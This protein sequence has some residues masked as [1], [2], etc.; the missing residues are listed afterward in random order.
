MAICVCGREPNRLGQRPN[1]RESDRSLG[2]KLG[3]LKKKT[4]WSPINLK[5]KNSKIS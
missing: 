2:R 3:F 5:F 4:L 1:K